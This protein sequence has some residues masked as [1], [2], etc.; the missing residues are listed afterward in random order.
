MRHLIRERD[1]LTGR[2]IFPPLLTT[3]LVEKQNPKQT[4]LRTQGHPFFTTHSIEAS[5]EAK[6]KR[7]LLTP[8][9]TT[10][11]HIGVRSIQLSLTP[12]SNAGEKFLGK[13]SN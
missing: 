6:E 5:N 11:L 9:Y 4:S 10:L 1:S 13:L 7:V 8:L 2:E 12:D 3:T